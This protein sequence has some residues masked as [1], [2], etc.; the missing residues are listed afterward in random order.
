MKISTGNRHRIG[1]IGLLLLLGAVRTGAQSDVVVVKNAGD[2]AAID[3]AGFA[4]AGPNGALFLQVLKNDLYRSGW[5]QVTPSAG[6][7]SVRGSFTENG[8][9]LGVQAAILKAPGRTS[10]LSRNWSGGR[11]DVRLLAHKVSDDLVKA[12]TGKEGFA[13]SRLALVGSRSGRKELYLADSDGANLTQLT[14]DRSISL[15]PRWS[16]DNRS[17][18]Y[19]SYL[20]K[21]PDLLRIDLAS[22]GRRKLASYRGLNIGGAFSPDGRQVALVLS[23]DGNPELYVMNLAD[24]S[25]TRLTRTPQANESSPCWSPD[26]RQIV[27][28]SDAAGVSRPQLYIMDRAGGAPRRVTSRGPQN[29]SPDWG[30]DGRIVF[31]SIAGREFSLCV[32][33]PRTL[34]VTTIAHD[35]SSYEEPSW[36]RDGRN[37]ACQRT[38]R[39][40]SGICLIDSVH[41]EKVMLLEEGG[42]WYSPAWQN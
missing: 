40:R 12:L 17:L 35:A 18:V 37:I 3:F 39:Y 5:F 25:L 38:I 41:K 13:Q 9:R 10:V 36:A 33:D 8:G 4:A 31:S 15:F 27:F 1:L 24:S 7:Y 14:R 19:T 20:N 30:P 21:F 16:P 28:V 42:D 29:V 2:R 6:E 22:G 11:S 26:G 34:E 23:K 32:L